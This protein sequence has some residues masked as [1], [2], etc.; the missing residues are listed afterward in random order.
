M[1]V[2][3][4]YAQARD[5]FVDWRKWRA[6][7][8]SPFWLLAP[9][10]IILSVL[11]VYPGLFSLS[12]ALHRRQY[13]EDVFVGLQNFALLAQS[14][15]TWQSI[16]LTLVFAAAYLIITVLLAL[17]VALLLNRHVRFTSVYMLMII[18]PW[19]LSDVVAGTMWR[20]MFISDYGILQEWI[21]PI[22]GR[23]L[24]ADSTGAMAIIVL[25]SV[26]RTLP[27]AVLLILAALQTLPREVLEHAALDGATPFQT[28]WHIVLPMIRPHLA[29]TILILSMRGIN[30]LG[31]ILTI[32][33]GGPARATSTL[34]YHLY[35]TAWQFGDF[36]LGAAIA[37]VMFGFNM[38]LTL[39]Y[40]RILRTNTFDQPV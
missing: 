19:V 33:A 10:L 6:R 26:W 8:R 37:I 35:Q 39:W 25:S 22:V 36:G 23:T 14:S 16:R 38:L 21:E 27:F 30:S 28:F 29:T 7:S 31:L 32:T 2:I 11:Q 20:W 5:T 1:Q 40:L 12:L 3:T 9:S 24:L 17:G 34:S 18:V 15:D 13:G 4:R